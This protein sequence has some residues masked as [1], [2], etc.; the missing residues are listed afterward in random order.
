[1]NICF[2]IGKIVEEIGFEFMYEDKRISIAYTKLKLKNDSIIEIRGYGKI[3][4]FMYRTLQKNDQ[5]IIQG[6][7]I[8]NK[9]DISRNKKNIT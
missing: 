6:S 3:A 7:I 8:D 9:I 4:D 1:M 2:E 5:I